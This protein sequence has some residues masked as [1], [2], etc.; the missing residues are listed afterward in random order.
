MYIRAE[1]GFYALFEKKND[2]DTNI[3]TSTRDWNYTAWLSLFFLIY[4]IM[5]W[6]SFIFC[7]KN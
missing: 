6:T 7:N 2:T 3:D 1:L 4:S 5:H